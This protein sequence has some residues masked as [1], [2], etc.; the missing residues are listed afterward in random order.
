M[1]LNGFISKIRIIVFALVF[2]AA[3]L[4]ITVAYGKLAFTPPGQI[5][6]KPETPRRG[7]IFDKNGKP[8]AVQTDFYHIAITP[9][10][11]GDIEYFAQSL[12]EA[13]ELSPQHITA[14]IKSAA[15]DFLYLK[16]KI[17]KA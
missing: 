2:T 10:A 8:L 3:A 16:K 4:Y 15:S 13:T 17:T 5:V 7:S 12:A 9:S 14:A 11:I 6:L 1:R